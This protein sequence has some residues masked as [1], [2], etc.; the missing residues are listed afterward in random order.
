MA[1]MSVTKG[2][3]MAKEN[4]GAAQSGGNNVVAMSLCPVEKCGKK[5]SRMEFC[6]EHFAWFK[7]GLVNR[8][9]EKPKDFDKKFQ[10]FLLRQKKA[11]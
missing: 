1:N 8:A 11:A 5:S 3:V 10:A 7:E 9:G 2:E 4:K 6:P